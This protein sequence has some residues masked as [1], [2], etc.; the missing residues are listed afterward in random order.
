MPRVGGTAVGRPP[1]RSR[2]IGYKERVPNARS[3]CQEICWGTLGR[4][5]LTVPQGRGRA[6]MSPKAARGGHR[7]PK[8]A[9]EA[10]SFGGTHPS[11]HRAFL[12]DVHT[13]CRPVRARP[14]AHNQDPLPLDTVA[15]SIGLQLETTR[16]PPFHASAAIRRPGSPAANPLV[17][18]GGLVWSRRR[19]YAAITNCL[20]ASRGGEG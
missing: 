14:R 8:N 16:V 17:D 7:G 12:T 3:G 4:P 10:G 11:S 9:R 5:C 2:S 13:G 20:L 15:S 19:R 1:A 18:G 6:S